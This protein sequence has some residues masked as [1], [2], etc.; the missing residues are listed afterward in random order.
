MIM[1]TIRAALNSITHTRI[2]LSLG[3]GVAQVPTFQV[4]VTF[5][6]V[7]DVLCVASVPLIKEKQDKE[8][9]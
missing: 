1:A 5:W 2:F 3:T 4:G 9:K 8:A 7:N 6:R